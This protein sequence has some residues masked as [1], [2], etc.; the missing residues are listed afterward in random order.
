M[1]TRIISVAALA[2]AIALGTTGCGFLVPQATLYEYAPSDGVNLELPG[3]DVRNLL[4]VAGDSEAN[5]VF[6]AVN[7]EQDSVRVGLKIADQGQQIAQT[8]VSLS[9]GLTVVGVDEKQIVSAPGLMPGSTIAVYLE[10][11]GVEIEKQVPVL[12][13]TLAEYEELVP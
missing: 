4:I 5:V 1:K 6:T 7:N 3:I 8:N 9:P 11:N 2:T 12:D 13:G 10:A